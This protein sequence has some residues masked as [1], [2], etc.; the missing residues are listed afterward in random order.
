MKKILTFTIMLTLIIG[1]SNSYARKNQQQENLPQWL[2]NTPEKGYKIKP[3][4]GMED[5]DCSQKEA[6]DKCSYSQK[7][8]G[9]NH[10][11]EHHNKKLEQKREKYENRMENKEDRYNKM[12]EK[13]KSEWEIRKN[14]KDNR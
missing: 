1:V 8:F 14:N 9:M 6:N 2:A 7:E 5:L 3:Y 11:R 10:N 4:E 12:M 13:R